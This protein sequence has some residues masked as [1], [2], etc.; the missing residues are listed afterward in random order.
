MRELLKQ[1]N[2]I[3]QQLNELQADVISILPAMEFA[4]ELF[5]DRNMSDE[6]KLSEVPAA[7]PEVIEA[8]AE[9]VAFSAKAVAEKAAK[10]TKSVAKRKLIQKA[11]PEA[12]PEATEPVTAS[13]KAENL[14]E[15][16]KEILE[17]AAPEPKKITYDD[18]KDSIY[19]FIK[20]NPAVN[21]PIVLNIFKER[22][23]GFTSD[24]PEA[25]YQLVIDLIRPSGE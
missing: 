5:A 9:T 22:G 15:R 21:K 2:D 8:K 16:T 20:E 1:I 23:Y 25:D 19:S 12:A 11:A 6:E 7:T 13:T 17:P 24:V 10:E 18:F 14:I 4:S 3:Q